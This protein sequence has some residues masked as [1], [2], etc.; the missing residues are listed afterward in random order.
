MERQTDGQTDTQTNRQTDSTEIIT[1]PAYADGKHRIGNGVNMFRWRIFL[2][3]QFIA[4]NW[5][6]MNEIGP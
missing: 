4:E 6:K 5:Y 2:F 1:Y 3:W